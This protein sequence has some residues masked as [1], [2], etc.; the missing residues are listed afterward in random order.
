MATLEV[1]YKFKKIDVKPLI[2]NKIE[3]A[4]FRLASIIL[5]DILFV[6]PKPPILEGNLRSSYTIIVNNKIALKGNSSQGSS[7][8]KKNSMRIAF[9][10][11]YA[12]K[13][14]EKPFNPGEIS[15]QDGGVGNKYVS[16]KFVMFKDKY[17]NF[18]K[19]NL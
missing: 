1:K 19:E 2:E 11:P 18:L 10:M 14:H 7:D 6:P 13:W 16:L 17:E 3:K 5:N 8:P 4:L 15:R 12:A 9:T